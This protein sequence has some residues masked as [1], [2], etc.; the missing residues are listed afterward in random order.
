MAKITAIPYMDHMKL[1]T[2]VSIIQKALA[3][4][5]PGLEIPLDSVKDGT[6][7]YLFSCKGLFNY[8]SDVTRPLSKMIG[9]PKNEEIGIA[10]GSKPGEVVI[11]FPKSKY[12]ITKSSS[13]QKP[14]TIKMFS[15]KIIVVFCVGFFFLLPFVL[16][17]NVKK[18]ESFLFGANDQNKKFGTEEQST[19]YISSKLKFSDLCNPYVFENVEKTTW[20][21]FTFYIRFFLKTQ[22]CSTIFMI[23]KITGS[24][25]E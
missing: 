20:S 16:Y 11:I 3:I 10:S 22:Y 23:N 6:H 21:I 5:N 1:K 13:H 18:E 4:N 15:S 17:F 8:G 12:L 7:G 24:N 25:T 14:T 9:L 19:T 2:D